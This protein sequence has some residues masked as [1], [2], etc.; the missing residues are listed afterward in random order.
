[1]LEYLKMRIINFPPSGKT[2]Y[3]RA[4]RTA[5]EWASPST[6]YSPSPKWLVGIEVTA[7]L[8]I[9]IDGAIERAAPGAADGTPPSQGMGFTA[10]VG[11]SG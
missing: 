5:G 9:V 11:A 6:S 7:P 3:P 1:M 2:S 10:Q 4:A 8:I